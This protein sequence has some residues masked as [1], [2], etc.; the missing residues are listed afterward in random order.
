M[1]EKAVKAEVKNSVLWIRLNRPDVLNAFN[2]QMGTDLHEALKDAEK[3]PKARA[4]VL[5][6]EGR[7]FSVGEDL[8]TSRVMYESGKPLL[9]GEVLRSKYNPIVARI[10]RMDKPVL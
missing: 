7:A 8:N 4:I 6:G 10:R 2:E 9:L 3:N 1:D 5:T